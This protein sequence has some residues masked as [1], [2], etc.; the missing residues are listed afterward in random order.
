MY[1]GLFFRNITQNAY[2]LSLAYFKNYQTCLK[3]SNSIINRNLN[4]RILN[5]ILPYFRDIFTGKQK[6]TNEFTG[7][8]VLHAQ[9]FSYFFL[10]FGA[11]K[12]L[13]R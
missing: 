12:L 3:Y 8:D 1:H 2:F 11:R 7:Q 6:T 10:K 4:L 13:A 9:F 5:L